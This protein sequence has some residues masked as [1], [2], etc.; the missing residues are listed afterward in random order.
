MK[1]IY[2]SRQNFIL[3]LNDN[4]ENYI[5]NKDLFNKIN[6]KKKEI[7]S[8][9]YKWD[10]AK[11]ISNDYEYIYTSSNYKK[12]ISSV[13]PVSRSFFKLRE[14]IYDYKLD[15]SDKYS[16]IAEAPGGFMQSILLY[17]K[18]KSIINNGIYGITLISEDKDIPYWNPTLL[19]NSKI[20]ISEGKDGTGDL[21][22][23]CN[24]LEFINYTGKSSCS[25]VTG[26]G[27]FDYTKDFEQEL[28][29]YKLF[30]SEIMIALNIQK[31]GGIFVCKMFDL[32]WYSTLQLVFILYQ[33]YDSISFIKPSTSRQS[34]SE[35]YIVCKG[36]KGYNKDYSNLM[37]HN[38]GKNM[39]PIELSREFINMIDLYH[40]QFINHQIRRIDYTLQLIIQ[41]RILDKPSKQQIKL[42]VEWCK[43]Y[44]I[45]V[46]KDCYYL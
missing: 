19:N 20:Y 36:F 35:K 42:A 32:F 16:C 46:N 3:K 41:R 21:Y 30:Y 29:S 28:S 9:Q 17:C 6:N 33:S 27:G 43:K 38:F 14:I 2:L 37:C 44:E 45:P 34:N 22:N 15:I 13:I 12:N 25:L 23:L 11:K 39:L 4:L 24:V 8:V 5:V 7:D 40:K 1:L 26:D 31:E 18:D 10:S